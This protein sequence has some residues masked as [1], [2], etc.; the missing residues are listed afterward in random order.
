MVGNFVG[1]CVGANDL[2]PQSAQSVPISHTALPSKALGPPSSQKPS[3]ECLHVFEHA[4]SDLVGA[5]VGNEDGTGEG[6]TVGNSDMISSG[7]FVGV[8]VGVGARPLIGWNPT[9]EIQ[10]VAMVDCFFSVVCHGFAWNENAGTKVPAA[11]EH[12]W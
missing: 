3:N 9:Y 1:I 5:G 10:D 4:L 12:F 7:Y 8:A 2:S 6:K 11:W